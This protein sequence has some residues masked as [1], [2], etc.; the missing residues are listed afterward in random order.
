MKLWGT[1]S[2]NIHRQPISSMMAP[3]YRGP[4]TEPASADA[5]TS[6][7]AIPLFSGATTPTAMARPMGTVAPPPTACST[8]ADTTQGKFGASATRADPM[9][10][11]TSAAWNILT[12]P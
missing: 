11:T 12:R 3:P 1:S 7:S 8:L 6:P 4:R 9:A 10:K 5:A 2:Q